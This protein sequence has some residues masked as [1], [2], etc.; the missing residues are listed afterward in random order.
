MLKF[1]K[2]NVKASIVPG[3]GL[4][5]GVHT[6][7]TLR[8]FIRFGYKGSGY[9]GSAA[10]EKVQGFIIG[11]PG[12]IALPII[13]APLFLISISMSIS[14]YIYISIYLYIYIYIS[15]YL[16]IYISIYLYIYIYMYK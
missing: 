2:R 15:I 3:R 5:E 7:F 1:H 4:K 14:L 13:Q 6:G 12:R 11:S 16:Y 10:L 8:A 9:K